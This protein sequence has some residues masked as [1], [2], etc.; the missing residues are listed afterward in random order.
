MCGRRVKLKT[1]K[2]QQEVSSRSS[3]GLKLH[4]RRRRWPAVINKLPHRKGHGLTEKRP[5]RQYPRGRRPAG[6]SPGEL[7]DL[8]PTSISGDTRPVQQATINQRCRTLPDVDSQQ[9]H[10]ALAAHISG[11][12]GAYLAGNGETNRSSPSSTALSRGAAIVIPG[13]QEV[14][15]RRRR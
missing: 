3:P 1:A 7:L 6:H 14:G 5:W 2:F 15:G 10:Q 4:R 12:G 13:L 9:L 8:A 11:A